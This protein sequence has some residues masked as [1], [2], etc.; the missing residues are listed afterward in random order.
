MAPTE[1]SKEEIGAVCAYSIAHARP[2]GGHRFTLIQDELLHSPNIPY[3][4]RAA[5]DP[6][7][8][9]RSAATATPG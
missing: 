5:M 4:R 8:R 9:R 1:Q 6:V 3:P 2:K 7:Q